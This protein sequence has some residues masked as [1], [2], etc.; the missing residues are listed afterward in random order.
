MSV[1]LYVFYVF[2]RTR[3]MFKLLDT[4]NFLNPVGMAVAVAQSHE[5]REKS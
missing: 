2:L 1:R 4:I 5:C 3:E